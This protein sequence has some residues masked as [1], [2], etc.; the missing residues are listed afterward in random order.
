MVSAIIAMI[1]PVANI[2]QSL[3][4]DDENVIETYQINM[5]GVPYDGPDVYYIMPDSYAGSKSLKTYWNFDNGD[6]ENFLTEN[7]FHIAQNSFSNYEYTAD[8][9]PSTMNMEYVHSDED[10]LDN[11]KK[12]NYNWLIF[13]NFRSKGYTTYFIES[14]LYLNFHSNNIDNKSCSP[15]DNLIVLYTKHTEYSMILQGIRNIFEYSFGIF[16]LKENLRDKI[17]CSFDELDKMSENDVRPKFVFTHIMAPH[18]PFVFGPT[19]EDPES[20]FPML[21]IYPHLETI[22]ILI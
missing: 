4:Y 22:S 5:D 14:G 10:P 15:L 7:G 3:I 19:G 16:L 1:M 20:L 13:D 11:S 8:S 9:I 2:G 12:D 18:S 17:I 6:F 21:V